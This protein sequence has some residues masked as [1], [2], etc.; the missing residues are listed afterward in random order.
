MAM[1]R[2]VIPAPFM[3]LITDLVVGPILKLKQVPLHINALL[4]A[5]LI[6]H[7]CMST[8]IICRSASS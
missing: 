2:V 8:C 3:A 7:I 6:Y 1:Q 5:M 4:S